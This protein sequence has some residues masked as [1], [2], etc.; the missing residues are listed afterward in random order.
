[1]VAASK[2]ERLLNLTALLL[3]TSRYLTADEIRNGLDAHP[4][5]RESFRRAFE[6]DKEE[7][8]AIGIPL[9]I[10]KVIGPS[11]VKIDA[12]RILPEE[13]FLRD[14]ELEPD[15]LAALHLAASAVQVEGLSPTGAFTKL[16]SAATATSPGGDLGVRIA[17]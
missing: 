17:P 2:L 9:S 14:P 13:Y 8:R 12:Y 1:A 16:G 11:N 7:L 10:K 5:N 15:E 6:R 3:N 4:E